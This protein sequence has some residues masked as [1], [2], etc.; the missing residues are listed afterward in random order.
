MKFKDA[1]SAQ[2]DGADM[3]DPNF[4]YQRRIQ[5]EGEVLLP[6]I[7][8]ITNRKFILKDYTLNIGHCLALVEVW[9]KLGLPEVDIVY[10]ANCGFDDEQFSTLL[11]GFATQKCL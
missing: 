3:N 2:V 5:E 6:L 11:T 4:I 1:S 8:K 7:N 10:L 9:Q